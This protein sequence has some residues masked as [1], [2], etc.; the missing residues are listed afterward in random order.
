MIRRLICKIFGHQWGA[1]FS[2]SSFPQYE[3]DSW[4]NKCCRCKTERFTWLR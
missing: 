3:P 2:T 4:K 1:K